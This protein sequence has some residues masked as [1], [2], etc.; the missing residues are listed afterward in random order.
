MREPR[1]GEIW[2]YESNMNIF[3][4][5]ILC[6]DG[7]EWKTVIVHC[8]SDPKVIGKNETM[9]YSDLK[10]GRSTYCP[11]YNTPLYKAICEK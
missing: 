11:L 5:K 8:P 6:R 9:Y 2:R 1:E 3:Y 7:D 4:E 10:Y